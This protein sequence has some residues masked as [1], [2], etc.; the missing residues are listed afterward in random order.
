M[1]LETCRR[2]VVPRSMSGCPHE[3]TH[4]AA[5]LGAV[6][7]SGLR[8]VSAAI[9]LPVIRSRSV[10]ETGD[11]RRDAIEFAYALAWLAWDEA[12]A[13]SL[14]LPLREERY[15]GMPVVAVFDNLLPDNTD[16]R[17]RV[18]ERVGAEGQD[19]YSLLAAIGR[20][21]VGALQFIP[22]DAEPPA[23]GVPQWD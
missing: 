15:V 22:D 18:A 7:G 12:F 17:R 1:D 6:I 9:P 13:I 16:I 10:I 23:A 4:W 3:G 11:I 5:L 14:S 2:S 20:D 21:C 8:A 19:A